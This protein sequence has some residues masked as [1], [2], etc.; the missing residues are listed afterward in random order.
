MLHGQHPAFPLKIV[1]PQA[2]SVPCR[3]GLTAGVFVFRSG[4]SGLVV[5]EQRFGVR[6]TEESLFEKGLSSRTP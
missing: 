3:Q 4:R 6:G 1:G 5:I 2:V